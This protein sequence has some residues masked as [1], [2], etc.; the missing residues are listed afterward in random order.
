MCVFKTRFH[1]NYLPQGNKQSSAGLQMRFRCIFSCPSF[2]SVTIHCRQ[3]LMTG[4]R[5]CYSTWTEHPV[6]LIP[7]RWLLVWEEGTWQ[8]NNYYGKRDLRGHFELWWCP[9]WRGNTLFWNWVPIIIAENIL[10]GMIAFIQQ[11]EMT[12]NSLGDR[13]T[14]YTTRICCSHWLQGQWSSFPFKLLCASFASVERLVWVCIYIYS[15]YLFIYLSIHT[16]SIY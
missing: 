2:S 14:M 9:Q 16:Q 5:L 7:K 12:T 1:L 3:H 4:S 15:I 10:K 6:V 13:T 8:G 11:L